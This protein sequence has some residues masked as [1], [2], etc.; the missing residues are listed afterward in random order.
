MQ[1]A[2][3]SALRLFV[4]CLSLG[5]CGLAAASELRLGGTG[6]ALGAM[7][8]IGN[9]FTRKNPDIQVTVLPSLGTSGAIKAVPKGAIDIGLGSRPLTEDEARTGTVSTE[10]A[11]SPLVFATGLKTKATGLT[12]DQIASIYTGQLTTWPDGTQIRPVL[13]QAGDDNTRQVRQMSAALDQALAVAE[14][15]PGMPFATNDQETADKLESIPGALGVTTL[16]LILSE[17]RALRALALDGVEPTVANGASGKYPHAKRLYYVVRAEPSAEV[18][19]F[20][21]FLTSPAGRE[22]LARTGHWV[23]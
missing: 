1:P 13:R 14:K 7:R 4:L 3:P 9:A 5:A 8:L 16:C 19:R 17:E 20:I 12:L 6:N 18:R 2:R 21:A 23:P 15:R 22:L 10:Y 11:R